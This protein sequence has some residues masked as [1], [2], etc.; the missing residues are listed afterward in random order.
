MCLKLFSIG[1][2]NVYGYGA[3]IALG[4]ICAMFILWKRAP[5]IGLNSDQMTGALL[6]LLITGFLGAKLLYCI[7]HFA[8]FKADP[9]G[10]LGSEGFVIYGGILVGIAAAYFWSR[11]KHIAF[12]DFLDTVFPAVAIAQGFGRIGCFLA[13]CCY[14]LPTDSFL[15]VVFPE[16]C[17]APAGIPLW[18]V[19]LFSS[20]Y[21]FLLGILILVWERKKEKRGRNLLIY[22]Y[23]YSIGRFVIE[24]FRNDTR[25][26]V[27]FLSTSQFISVL[28]FIFAVV[29]TVSLRKKAKAVPA[30]DVAAEEAAEPAEIVPEE[31]ADELA[32]AAPEEPTAVPAEDTEASE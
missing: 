5:R 14:G 31:T 28:V 27:G 18:P 10:T 24:Y 16:G 9:L 32:E 3:M 19:Q 7:A 25:G 30:A 12:V 1:P 6:L 26:Q 23:G 4:V 22:L 2:I 20:G 29:L 15:G 11:K 13:G 21:D 17:G 8:D